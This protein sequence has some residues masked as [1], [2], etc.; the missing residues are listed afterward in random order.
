ME[1]ITISMK[2]TESYPL[3]SYAETT[4]EGNPYASVIDFNI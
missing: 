2:D 1:T 4:T 3:D